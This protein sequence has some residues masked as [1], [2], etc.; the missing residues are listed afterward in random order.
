MKIILR[1]FVKFQ[2]ILKWIE[3]AL[4]NNN[5]KKYP[6]SLIVLLLKSVN[7][8]CSFIEEK[9]QR[10]ARLTSVGTYLNNLQEDC[11]NSNAV[12]PALNFPA[13]VFRL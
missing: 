4:G 9:C 11:L 13:V 2:I 6:S 10:R 8:G 7:S 5:T 3:I 1:T 12:W